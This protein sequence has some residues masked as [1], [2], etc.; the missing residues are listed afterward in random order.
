[1]TANHN[2]LQIPFRITLLPFKYHYRLQKEILS[3]KILCRMTNPHLA[4]SFD[5]EIMRLSQA[6][7]LSEEMNDIA[8][9]G[10]GAKFVDA[11]GKTLVHWERPIKP[12]PNGWYLNYRFSQPELEQTL[13]HGVKLT[14]REQGAQ[15]ELHASYVVGCDGGQSFT[16]ENIGAKFEDLGF[17]E[18]WLIVDLLLPEKEVEPDRFTYHYCG[19]ARMGLNT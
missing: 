8:E 7:E 4:V 12:T 1:M 10:A 19:A 5:D 15:H 6:M 16:R 11:E 2:A 14:Y 3:G 9:V 13:Q 17:N 18:E